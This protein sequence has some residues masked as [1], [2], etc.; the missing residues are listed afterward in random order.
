[1]GP[2]WLSGPGTDVPAEPPLKGPGHA[3]THTDIPHCPPPP[4]PHQP[5]TPT[6][7]IGYGYQCLM[8]IEVCFNKLYYL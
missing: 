1:M 7:I 3:H 6:Q 2:F 4:F 8:E 5:P